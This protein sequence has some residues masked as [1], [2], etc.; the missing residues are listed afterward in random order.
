MPFR[1][2]ELIGTLVTVLRRRLVPLSDALVRG[3]VD[4]LDRV[5]DPG[6]RGRAFLERLKGLP[7]TVGVEALA[8][9]ERMATLRLPP[10]QSILLALLDERMVREVLPPGVIDDI[11][12]V[13]RLRGYQRITEL[14]LYTSAPDAR[15][16]GVHPMPRD[17]RDIPLGRRRSLARTGIIHVLQRLTNDNDAEVIRILLGNPRI[18]EREV[19]QITARR[20]STPAILA[21]IAAHPRWNVRYPVKKALV[22]NPDTPIHLSVPLLRYLL[23]QDLRELLRAASTN[24]FLKQAARDLVDRR[25]AGIRTA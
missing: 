20:P 10:A 15:L 6:I 21:V 2:D 22:Y 12:R 11:W 18:T 4:G 9:L 8:A 14:F 19:V 13:A 17:I 5:A 7:T 25:R 24:E 23:E 16:A 3:M 1:R